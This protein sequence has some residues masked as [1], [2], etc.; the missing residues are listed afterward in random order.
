MRKDDSVRLR[1]MLDSAGDVVA[2]SKGRARPDLETDRQLVLALVKAVSS[3]D[4][5]L[6]SRRDCTPQL[7][8]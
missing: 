6:I 2:F 1:H 7:W 4:T 8:A 3:G 5:Y